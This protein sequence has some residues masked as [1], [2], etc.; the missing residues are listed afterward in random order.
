M[1]PTGSGRRVE[2][3]RRR[4][5]CLARGFRG[6]VSP[7]L[8][9]GGYHFC[10]SGAGS[11]TA[12]VHLDAVRPAFL[13]IRFDAI[14]HKQSRGCN[15]TT[16]IQGTPAVCLPAADHGPGRGWVATADDWE[17]PA[18]RCVLGT[19]DSGAQT[20]INAPT[21]GVGDGASDG[22]RSS[23]ATGQWF[24]GP[25]SASHPGKRWEF[26][27]RESVCVCLPRRE[28]KKKRS[29]VRHQRRRRHGLRG[30]H[31]GCRDCRRVYSLLPFPLPPSPPPPP[32]LARSLLRVLLSLAWS[33]SAT[34]FA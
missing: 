1:R 29:E 8:V 15:P 16:S 21:R 7:S 33:S 26:C 30:P 17:A 4:R 10:R 31:G 3:H 12:S 23:P 13:S 22:G 19:R 9:S 27:E 32:F 28:G 11:R 6:G 2:A 20:I 5:S 18:M 25:P 24:A 34:A 14:L